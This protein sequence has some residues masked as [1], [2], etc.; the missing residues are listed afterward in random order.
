MHYSAFSPSSRNCWPTLC[1][2]LNPASGRSLYATRRTPPQLTHLKKCFMCPPLPPLIK[3]DLCH[4]P[5]LL[6]RHVA[7]PYQPPIW[8][9]AKSF[10]S[11]P[12]ISNSY[13]ISPT[14]AAFIMPT[15]IP[16]IPHILILHNP[17]YLLPP[18][19]PPRLPGPFPILSAHHRRPTTTQRHTGQ[20]PYLQTH[21]QT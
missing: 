14:Y 4:S 1:A 12:H 21:V 17:T 7:C 20:N 18:L 16:R 3:I 13:N 19:P 2:N 8:I 5:S 15:Y 6:P 10:S 9:L 11:C